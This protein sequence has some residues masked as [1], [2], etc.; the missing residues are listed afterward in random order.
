MNEKKKE[1]ALKSI[2]RWVKC[3]ER[4]GQIITKI[5]IESFSENPYVETEPNRLERRE[6]KVTC[7]V[8]VSSKEELLKVWDKVIVLGYMA[9][10]VEVVEKCELCG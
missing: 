4:R 5:V 6:S 10:Q 8:C 2:L 9:T 7:R 3:Y 1:R